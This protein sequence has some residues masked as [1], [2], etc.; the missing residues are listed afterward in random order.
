MLMIICGGIVE[1]FL[2]STSTLMN[3]MY[4]EHMFL[5]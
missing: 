2:P 1:Y 4:F 3:F 5:L